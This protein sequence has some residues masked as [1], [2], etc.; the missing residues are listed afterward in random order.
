M[1]SLTWPIFACATV[2]L[3]KFCHGTPLTEINDAVN[4]GPVFVAPWTVDASAA[5]H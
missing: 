2:D 4:D 3:E 1:V 5:I